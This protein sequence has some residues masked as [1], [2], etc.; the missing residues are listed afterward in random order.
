MRL[1]LFI[2]ALLLLSCGQNSSES[3]KEVL[4]GDTSKT[5]ATAA[6]TTAS[7]RDSL[8][9][10]TP[11]EAV[12]NESLK[13]RYG[14]KWHVLNDSEAKW[15]KDAFDYFIVSRRKADPNYP[16]IAKGDYNADGKKDTAAVVTDSLKTTYQVVILLGG[17]K[18]LLWKEDILEDA[19]ISTIPKSDIEGM[20]GEKT[21]K[22]K[23]KGDGI[24]VEYFEKAAFV[25]YWDKN[26]FKRIQTAD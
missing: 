8:F 4:H 23:M 21:K 13:S 6:Q 11:D 1:L 22:V 7:A 5:S 25:L 16:Y 14:T 17:G 26:N 3:K 9:Y 2:A 24:N 12:V 19:A 15:M 20:D 18:S 10:T